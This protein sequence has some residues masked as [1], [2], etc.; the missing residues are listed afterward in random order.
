MLFVDVF[1]RFSFFAL[2][3]D[4][5]RYSSSIEQRQAVLRDP[6][7]IKRLKTSEQRD[8]HEVADTLPSLGHLRAGFHR[9]CR[10]GGIFC[11]VVFPPEE[12]YTLRWFR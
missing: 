3:I 8:S 10:R 5:M 4:A 9:N 2:E 1:S 12:L 7:K 6:K 11:A